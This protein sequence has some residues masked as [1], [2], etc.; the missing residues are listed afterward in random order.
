MTYAFLPAARPAVAPRALLVQA[1]LEAQLGSVRR[2]AHDDAIHTVL[3][4]L[5][6]HPDAKPARLARLVRALLRDRC[7]LCFGA[8]GGVRGA[9]TEAGGMLLCAACAADHHCPE[10]ASCC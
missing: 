10:G 7:E 9:E 8:R 5:A 3:D 2:T 6:R 1:A 4:L